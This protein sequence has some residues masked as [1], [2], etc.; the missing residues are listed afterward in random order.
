MATFSCSTD[1]SRP[2]DSI[3]PPN[4]PPRSEDPMMVLLQDFYDPYV[5]SENID[6][7]SLDYI[8][9][10]SDD[11]LEENHD[12]IQ[13][14]FPLKKGSKYSN[15]AP[16]ISEDTQAYM[17]YHRRFTE[18]IRLALSRMM[19][20]YGFR[21]AYNPAKGE[22]FEILNVPSNNGLANPYGRWLKED[23]HNHMRIARMIRSL[24]RFRMAE[25][26]NSVLR[27]FLDVNRQWGGQVSKKVIPFWEDA[28]VI[29]SLANSWSEQDETVIQS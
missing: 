15:T 23:D 24:A 21:V 11:W 3:A 13:W 25:E 14:L 22:G 6:N 7:R 4:C 29:K 28:E 16:R 2:C 9:S 17:A 26:A 1:P 12:Y 27:A 5:A 18:Q 8:L 20:F 10:Q 19:W